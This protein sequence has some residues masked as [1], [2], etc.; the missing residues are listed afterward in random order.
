MSRRATIPARHR[1]HE[2]P[3]AHA[4]PR[5]Y[6]APWAYA[7]L[8][9]ALL[10]A[11][12]PSAQAEDPLSPDEVRKRSLPLRTALHHD[13]TLGSPL[14]RLLELYRKASRTEELVA[15]YRS[16]LQQ[17][18]TDL[19]ARI[20]HVRLL[21]AT[22]DPEASRDV[23]SA[24]E[25]HP[26]NGYLQHLLYT[27][28]DDAT[29]PRAL[30][31]LD[32]AV[33]L[34]T[35]PARKRR[36][37]EQLLTQALQEDRRALAAKH[38]GE[39]A[40]LLGGGAQAHLDAARKM[41][42]FGFH[43]RA[44]KELDGARKAKPAPEVGVETELLAA[45]LEVALNRRSAAADRLDALLKRLT[46]DYW[47]RSEILRR[48]ARL[49]SSAKERDA[50]L[51]AA[52]K[53]SAERPQDESAALD[54]ARL[55][56][57]FERHREALAGLRKAGER[58]PASARLEKEILAMFERLRDERG[59]SS[60][61]EAR[62]AAFPDRHDLV[63]SRVR[64]L[65]VLGRKQKAREVLEG[66]LEKLDEGVRLLRLLET[67]RF[68]RVRG[69]PSTAAD[70]YAR[71]VEMAPARLDVRREWAEC[72]LAVGDR[73]GARRV[74]AAPIPPET[75]KDVFLDLMQLLMN[76][77]LYPEARRA[78]KARIAVDT[79]DLDIHL[80]LIDVE[81][82]LGYG[83][84]GARWVEKARPLADTP[85][86]YRRWLEQAVSLHEFYEGDEGFLDDEQA[87][88]EAATGVAPADETWP[89]KRLGR[90]EAFAEISARSDRIDPI[91]S[92]LQTYLGGDLPPTVRVRLRRKLAALLEEA[93]RGW[94]KPEDSHLGAA[95]D[96]LQGLLREDPEFAHEYRARLALI[97]VSRKRL[98]LARPL[99]EKLEVRRL[100]DTSMLER[101]VRAY[102][103]LGDGLHVL[104]CLERLTVV[105]ASDRGHWEDWIAA[106]TSTGEEHKLR[107]AIRR[108]LRGIPRMKLGRDTQGELKAHL[109]AS[110]WRAIGGRVAVR[111]EAG[112]LD[113]LALLDEVERLSAAAD[114]PLWVAWTRAYVHNALGRV[115]ARDEAM[116]ELDR[117]VAQRRANSDARRLADATTAKEAGGQAEEE[118]DAAKRERLRLLDRIDFPDGLGASWSTA[119]SLLTTQAS[120]ASDPRPTPIDRKGP[121]GRMHVRWAFETAGGAPVTAVLP[122]GADRLLISD[123]SGDLHGVERTSGKVL[124]VRHGAFAARAANNTPWAA[125]APARTPLLGEN[126]TFYVPR[127]GGAICYDADGAKRWEVT[128]GRGLATSHAPHLAADGGT[129]YGYD[130]ASGDVAA[131]RRAD[132]KLRWHR[133]LT[134]RAQSAPMPQGD[135]ISLQAG[136]LLVYGPRTAVLD[137]D[138]GASL[139]TFEPERVRRVPFALDEP[140]DDTSS[141]FGRR[142]RRAPGASKTAGST[143]TA[144]A[145]T[146]LPSNP[147]MWLSGR[148]NWPAGMNPGMMGWPGGITVPGIPGFGAVTYLTPGGRLPSTWSPQGPTK[149]TAVVAP[150]VRWATALGNG[151]SR[152]GMLVGRHLLL[153]RNDAPPN[154]HVAGE[155]LQLDLDLPL[156]AKQ[157]R[158]SGTPVARLGSR[159]AFL[160]EGRLV[161]WDVDRGTQAVLTLKAIAG[162]RT[163]FQVNTAQDGSFVYLT[164]PGG[165]MCV[166]LNGLREVFHTAWPDAVRPERTDDPTWVQFL[167]HGMTSWR[168]GGAIA[169]VVSPVGFA[170]VSTLYALPAPSR[171]VALDDLPAGAKPAPP[172]KE[173]GPR[174]G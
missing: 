159:I 149:P 121:E 152:R 80:A 64:S 171:V 97:H 24:V 162:E 10:L 127:A 86:R 78:L 41:H 122:L 7:L 79:E 111:N 130:P 26:K 120:D 100:N 28:L 75:P 53:R 18:P 73:G 90:L 35:Q 129:L 43:E 33:E 37:I 119:R 134:M 30:D 94:F 91:T 89:E 20:V 54:L 110:Y 12:G 84:S 167:L 174:G 143:R 115:K 113:A 142:R 40:R 60:Y 114:V 156:F 58:L 11:G 135:G 29:D 150:A 155:A 126:G 133:T 170:D 140:D 81:G 105:S 68:L 153:L 136:R 27:L 168:Q 95:A 31:A 157:V 9:T 47:R 77:Y 13:P 74:L 93:G 87:R 15:L 108:L 96:E 5:A 14:E 137:T 63:E 154:S 52:R 169:P 83:T 145:P 72:H 173:G 44:L 88:I 39:L 23:R 32:K 163:R 147:A 117:L 21:V 164:G 57:G 144:A 138:N 6:A 49:V 103:E 36:W 109:R 92:L 71:V 123:T 62:S 16:H 118:P 46:A 132:G 107:S 66:L 17:Y 158:I 67:A 125:Y 82:S 131:F 19:S 34:E 55:L 25:Q 99:L 124:W 22:N 51:D 42:A 61:L 106:L 45:S 151:A 112:Y 4:A 48:R 59:R 139:W 38:L 128:I 56:S 141:L 160:Q 102:R 8:V 85:A 2:A 69:L 50:M 76:Q 116:G 70:L 104:Q 165:L 101:L 161:L 146:V 166:N 1:G 3:S 65:Y 148:R 98:D 172:K